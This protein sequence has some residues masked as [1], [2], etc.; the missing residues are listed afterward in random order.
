MRTL[1]VAV[2]SLV[3][4]LP[5]AGQV[6][7]SAGRSPTPVLPP[8]GQPHIEGQFVYLG[9][10][11]HE[12]TVFY[13]LRTPDG[14]LAGY[15]KTVRIPLPNGVDPRITAEL[16]RNPDGT[17]SYHYVVANLSGAR[18]A[19]GQWSIP[20]PAGVGSVGGPQGWRVMGDRL[21]ET[22]YQP[23]GA[24]QMSPQPPVVTLT[25]SAGR[26]VAPGGIQSG[27]TIRSRFAPALIPAF[28]AAGELQVPDDLPEEVRKQLEPWRQPESCQ[29]R[30][31][32][33]GPRY[34]A[35]FPRAVVAN[36]F[37]VALDIMANEGELD[38]SSRFVR[39]AIVQLQSLA[40]AEGPGL[41]AA[42][43][44]GFLSLAV[45][46]REKELAEAIRLALSAP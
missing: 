43:E 40:R 34:P 15:Q 44:L 4:L 45:T 30:V 24:E 13:P 32:V 14:T 2:I 6:A 33:I 31:W 5:A 12:L 18:Q 29:R 27:F 42:A 19:L 8:S 36:E 39:E 37:G 25:W 7:R 35:S 23:Q 20:V 38:A 9:P 26:P 3:N 17:F 21:A 10:T 46:A 11:V 28:A 1:A 22:S 41:A 16:G